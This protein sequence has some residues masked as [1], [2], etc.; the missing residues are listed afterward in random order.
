MV[1]I[2]R[3]IF[4]VIFLLTGTGA[5]ALAF[6]LFTAKTQRLFFEVP[7]T[8]IVLPL[9]YLVA[10][11]GAVLLVL[12]VFTL[13]FGR[14][15]KI[16]PARPVKPDPTRNV[17]VAP[18][19]PVTETSATPSK[20]DLSMPESPPLPE[21]PETPAT[22][23][24]AQSK[25]EIEEELQRLVVF[26]QQGITLPRLHLLLA[27]FYPELME[28]EKR[29]DPANA[30]TIETVGRK[31]LEIARFKVKMRD[32]G[33]SDNQFSIFQGKAF[34]AERSQAAQIY[35]PS[36]TANLNEIQTQAVGMIFDKQDWESAQRK[37]RGNR[38]D[39]AELSFANAKELL[40]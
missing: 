4:G 8:N 14:L 9:G 24:T 11:I 2:L 36:S 39:W 3:F 10:G 12:T 15:K 30:S 25:S 20:S 35:Q 22:V 32:K 31:I 38:T 40:G 13:P 33:L 19:K 18:P 1:L 16:K 6:F 21:V 28:L 37:I 29:I 34:N 17:S 5:G 27:E 7:L 23:Q 26:E